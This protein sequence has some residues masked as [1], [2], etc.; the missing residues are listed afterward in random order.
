MISSSAKISQ[1]R[2]TN[3]K[4]ALVIDDDE[5]TADCIATM[6]KVRMFKSTIENC[7][8]QALKRLE[9]SSFDFIIM[10]FR[11]SGMTPE[12]FLGRPNVHHAMIN[13]GTSFANPRE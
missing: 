10:D 4:S 9:I 11:M 6:L 13:M 1:V 5:D 3:A 8:E 7:R 12:V 2:P